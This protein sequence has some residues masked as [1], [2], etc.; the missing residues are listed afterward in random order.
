MKKSFALLLILVVL[1]GCGIFYAQTTLLEEKDKVVFTETVLYGDKS[2]AENVTVEMKNCCGGYLFWDSVYDV[3]TGATQTDY[4]FYSDWQEQNYV[5]NSEMIEFG[6]MPDVDLDYVDFQD[7]TQE[8]TGLYAAFQELYDSMEPGEEAD[9]LV[10]LKDYM[11]YY[12]IQVT[13]NIS[14]DLD[15]NLWD[16][17][18]TTEMEFTQKRKEKEWLLTMR[19]F[20]K[21]PVIED[22]MINI[23]MCLDEN[24]NVTGYGAGS[25]SGAAAHGDASFPET[26]QGG[27]NFLPRMVETIK[28]EDLFF[29]F[30]T[31]TYNDKTVDTSLIPG[32]YGIY[33]LPY[34]E[35][36]GEIYPE[37]LEMVYALDPNIEIFDLTLDESEENFLLFSFENGKCMLSV[38]DAETMELKQ[39][40]E[41]PD[42]EGY[43][44]H[45][46][47]LQE[48]FMVV[49]IKDYYVL[50]RNSDGAFNLEFTI[51]DEKTQEI[52]F[53]YIPET[54]MDY[55]DTSFDWNGEQLIVSRQ[56]FDEE[57]EEIPCF[58]VAVFDKTEIL[59]L[60]RYDSTLDSGTLGYQFHKCEPNG[61][62]SVSV[63]WK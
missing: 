28:G 14:N 57:W 36:K 27:D 22:E 35:E 61:D 58:Y 21:I 3:G 54:D 4:E 50:T 55:F 29:T 12:P 52:F 8:K 37:K 10:Y 9:K 23:F 39:K 16:N 40:L 38:I 49:K 19:E 62:Y 41:M 26:V 53:D 17:V 43:F 45:A 60:G 46:Y 15:F 31:K 34:D 24:G 25:R 18:L 20:F 44:Y 47:W 59:Y 7:K 51:D 32:G 56:L 5:Y 48:D 33:V 6:L 63:H 11:E 42:D 2:A 13:I 30:S 1:S